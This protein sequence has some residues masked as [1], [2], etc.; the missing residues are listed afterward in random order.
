VQHAMK[1]GLD[2]PLDL[3]MV[4]RRVGAGVRR[5]LNLESGLFAAARLER[6]LVEQLRL[7]DQRGGR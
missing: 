6:V 5:D 4:E 2:A 1:R 7:R 3:P